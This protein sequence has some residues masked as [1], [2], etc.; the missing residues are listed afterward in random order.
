MKPRDDSVLRKAC[1][2]VLQPVVAM[3]F[4]VGLRWQ[5]YL[6]VSR[7]VFIR[8]A[9]EGVCSSDKRK[10]TSVIANLTGIPREE[11]EGEVAA[12][13]DGE[14]Y[15]AEAPLNEIRIL[16]GWHRDRDFTNAFGGPLPL[17]VDGPVPS[18]RALVDR[19]GTDADPREL[20]KNLI[21]NS[22]AVINEGGE[23]VA[24]RAYFIPENSG[25]AFLE[26][27]S[28]NL[29]FHSD[30]LRQNL[31]SDQAVR[32]FEGIAISDRAAPDASEAFRSFINRRAEQFLEEIDTWLDEYSLH[33]N[34]LSTTP[35]LLGVG[36]YAID[37]SNQKGTLS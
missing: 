6:S 19:Y 5:D 7:K 24:T 20:A 13:S 21:D 28:A 9:R 16:T 36:I 29:R 1:V 15:S 30:T 4:S 18:F 10:L 8:A 3:L 14:E 27:C 22:S 32:R 31:L 37:G 23:L 33:P 12:L 17:P 35:T 34:D 25:L 2:A 11:V 26:S